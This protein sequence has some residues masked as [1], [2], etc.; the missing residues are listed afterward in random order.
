MAHEEPSGSDEKIVPAYLA[1]ETLRNFIDS[2]H[3]TAVPDHIGRGLMPNLSNGSQSHVLHALKFLRLIEKNGNSS[4]DLRDLAAAFGSEAWA[5]KLGKLVTA[6]YAPIL[7]DLNIASTTDEKLN[8]AFK[9]KTPLEPSVLDRAVRFFI[10]AMREAKVPLS[11]HLGK[12]KTRLANKEKTAKP[13][14]TAGGS[15]DR[16]PDGV[17]DPPPAKT[18]G[19]LPVGMIDFP[20]PIAAGSFIRVPTGITPSQFRLVKAIMDVVEAMSKQNAPEGAKES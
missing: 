7:G 9:D 6:A 20:I 12:R 15:G 4:S 18:T 11:P 19:P 1:N 5:P 17:T 16:G 8:R 3:T 10:K 2:L 13:A 14:A